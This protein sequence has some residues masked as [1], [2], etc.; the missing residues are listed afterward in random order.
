MVRET[1]CGTRAG[2]RERASITK[3]THRT[4]PTLRS[5]LATTQHS[6]SHSRPKLGKQRADP[7]LC[8]PCQGREHAPSLLL[9]T[10]SGSAALLH[11][12]KAVARW[13]A[14]AR[15]RAAARSRPAGRAS[16]P[17]QRLLPQPDQPLGSLGLPGPGRRPFSRTRAAHGEDLL[18][19]R[20]P[21][22]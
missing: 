1:Y 12:F 6:S 13:L 17:F 18:V 8:E 10:A 16:G 3:P 5:A 11:G 21:A 22:D 4:K 14:G 7:G 19:S 2:A 9:A 15:P 20:I